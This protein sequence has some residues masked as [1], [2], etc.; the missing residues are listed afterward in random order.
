MEYQFERSEFISLDRTEPL[1]QSQEQTLELR[2]PEGYPEIGTV[3]GAW[4]QAM[5]RGKH[6][7]D[8]QLSITGGCQLWVLY[9]P[10]EGGPVQSV[11]GWLPF[12][13]KWDRPDGEPEG[14]FHTTCLLRSADARVLSG[15]KLMLRATVAVQLQAYLP[16]PV[17]LPQAQSLPEDIRCKTVTHDLCLLREAGEKAFAI[18]EELTLPQTAQELERLLA[19]RLNCRITEQK[20][21]TDKL[22]FRGNTHLHILYRGTDGK[23]HTWDFETPFSQYAELSQLQS[24]KAVSQVIPMLTALEL[25]LD[26]GRL[27]LKAGFTGQFLL[28][29]QVE[30]AVT[31][32]AYSL[33]RPV[34]LCKETVSAATPKITGSKTA[35]AEAGVN[36]QAM[37]LI[38]T[39]FY[40][41]QPYV[42]ITGDGVSAELSGLFQMLYYDEED[43]LQTSQARWEGSVMLEQGS[44]TGLWTIWLSPNIA[45]GEAGEAGLRACCTVTME[46]DV[47]EQAPLEIITALSAPE[48]LKADP[49]RP[50]LILRRAGSMSLW[51]LAKTCG[52]TEELI[53][54]ANNLQGS[55]EPGKMLLIPVP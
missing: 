17:V 21:M 42:R 43:L 8:G 1:V 22:V 44:P 27:R 2:L 49:A 37:Q 38:D 29:D 46:T 50:S 20:V 5:L 18:D 24:E 10:A 36:H 34:T 48:E 41:D 45:E 6:W 30:V 26:E 16:R 54:Q 28:C 33:L 52:S 7:Q 4:G 13:M 25:T 51:E 9:I 14:S 39:A 11:Q 55:P 19:S 35:T 3:A 32:D 47:T 23:L 53:Q 15:R 31:E 12:Q 40:P